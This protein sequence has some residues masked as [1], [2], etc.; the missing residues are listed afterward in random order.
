MDK[1][2]LIRSE[3]IPKSL[4]SISD[5]CLNLPP[6]LVAAWEHLL[7]VGGLRAEAMKAIEKDVIGGEGDEVTNQHLAS[8]F[9]GSCARIQLAMLDPN[10][11][12]PDVANAFAKLFS[13]GRVLLTDVPSGSGAAALT[14]LSTIAEL[15]RQNKIPRIPLTVILV[16]GEIS[17]LAREYSVKGLNAILEVLNAQAIWVEFEFI[18]WD[19]LCK[20]STVSLIKRITILGDTCSARALVLANFSGFLH[21]GTNWKK[22]APQIE[23]LFMHSQDS[24]SLAIWLEPKKGNDDES[25][26]FLYRIRR[27]FVEKLPELTGSKS[28]LDGIGNMGMDSSHAQHP[29]RIG[30]KFRVNLAVQ[31]FDLPLRG[32]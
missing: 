6:D 8:K 1:S 17:P 19:V 13:G 29:L 15:R 26:G 31:R 14:I 11:K 16:G 21:S 9:T 2:R 20:Y 25:N 23:S 27:W 4:W 30:H 22:A 5:G 3:D 32:E 12:I 24:Q 18:S 7:D 28:G 10:E